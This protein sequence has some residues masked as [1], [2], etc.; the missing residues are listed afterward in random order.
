MYDC[1][2]CLSNK[3]K[4]N[5]KNRQKVFANARFVRTIVYLK[6][7]IQFPRFSQIVLMINLQKDLRNNKSIESGLM[8]H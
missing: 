2:W 5:R 6:K 7:K 3:N 1:L 4:N 8:Y